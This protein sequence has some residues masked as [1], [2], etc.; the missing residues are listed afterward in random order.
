MEQNNNNNKSELGVM[1]TIGVII[2]AFIFGMKPLYR[3]LSN[4]TPDIKTPNNTPSN[5]VKPKE[6]YKIL[7]PIGDN[8]LECKKDLI[9]ENGSKHITVTL[10]Y[11]DALT[12]I[13][14]DYTYSSSTEDFSNY[15]MSEYNKFKQR[16]T[17][18]NNLGYSVDIKMDGTSYLNIS[19]VYL[20]DTIDLTDINLAEN[21][22]M[23]VIG[24]N[25]MTIVDAKQLYINKGYMCGE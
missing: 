23:E 7:K 22:V 25:K 16:K 9:Q 1:I 10:Y 20:L 13:K 6:E 12:S 19:S 2:V 24:D 5:E 8:T 21:D 11:N 4:M 15:L 3:F 18:N 14:E 17:L